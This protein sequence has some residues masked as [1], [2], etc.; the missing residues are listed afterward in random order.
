MTMPGHA[1]RNDLALCQFDRGKQSGRP[2]AFVVVRERLQSTGK[3]PQAFLRSVERLN[4]ALLV[5]REDQRMFR[6]IEI[7]P[8][9]VHQFLGK[10]GVVGRLESFGQMA[11]GHC[12]ATRD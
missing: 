4:L 7:Q 3:Q 1:V 2:V 12:H 8:N 6:R 5:A 9:N 10:L 11:S